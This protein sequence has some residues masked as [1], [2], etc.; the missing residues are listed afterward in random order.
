M[1]TTSVSLLQERRYFPALTGLR[2]IAAFMIFLHHQNHI[3]F[4][5]NR[6]YW[7]VYMLFQE[8]HTGVSIFFVLSGFLVALRYLE[9]AKLNKRWLGNYFINRFARIW[10]LY[11]FVLFLGPLVTGWPDDRFKFFLSVTLLK[12]FFGDL[13]F[14][15]IPQ[16]WSLTVEETFY[17]FAP[18]I[19][20]F[21]QKKPKSIFRTFLPVPIFLFIGWVLLRT[22]GFRLQWYNLFYD[23]SFVLFYTFFGRCFEFFVG[24]FFARL[25][26]K[27]E[28]GSL[29]RPRLPKFMTLTGFVGIFACLCF[30]IYYVRPRGQFFG[31][32]GMLLLNGIMPLFIGCLIFGLVHEQTIIKRFLSTRTFGLLGKT[33]YAFYLLDMT[34]FMTY[35]SPYYVNNIVGSG[36]VMSVV[37]K[38][39][40]MILIAIALYFVVEN[41]FN[42]II[43]RLFRLKDSVS[44]K[45]K[46]STPNLHRLSTDPAE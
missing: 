22:V 40:V 9:E 37:A 8:F 33:S 28:K 2:F 10:P 1:D 25:F 26:L 43:R 3:P 31:A 7:F 4:Q 45:L 20:V 21:L 6:V 24:I 5:L 30:M 44:Q 18:F 17:F 41:P 35:L 29:N 14:I 38:F 36:G 32:S 12:G 19:F 16:A 27:W 13:K 23:R 39:L 15:G 11:W 34:F 46:S 42:Y